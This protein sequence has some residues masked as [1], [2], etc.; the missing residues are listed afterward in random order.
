MKGF[1]K[2]YGAVS[3]INAIAMGKGVAFGID[4]KTEAEVELLSEDEFSIC[5]EGHPNEDTTLAEICVRS[6]LEKY[7]K[8]EMHGAIVKTVSE[9]PISMGLKSS[10]SASGAVLLATYDALSI[11]P[12]FQELLNIS[13][14]ASIKA[15]VSITGAF[16]DFCACTLG[17]VNFTDNFSRELLLR[18][19]MPNE[20]T[21]V[22]HLPKNRIRKS[23][24]PVQ[25]MREF[26]NEMNN[27]YE[28]A[29]SGDIFSAMIQNG[30]CVCKALG[31]SPEVSERALLCGAFAAGV[32]G[33]GPATGILVRTEVLDGFLDKFTDNFR[34]ENIITAN[35]RNGDLV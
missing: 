31:V 12:N 17:G 14:D 22:I 6:V 2:A 3:I 13:C 8:Y 28:A 32:S 34:H 24:F 33:T 11:T 10:S 4:K 7:P 21:V 15:G 19:A 20:F 9:I 16:D 23:E 26:T 1:G 29:V 5:I 18:K 25:R 35:I 27:A 30:R